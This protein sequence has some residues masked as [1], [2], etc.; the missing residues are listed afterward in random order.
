M[1]LIN[2]IIP[3]IAALL[4]LFIIVLID[5]FLQLI[6]MYSLRKANYRIALV[7]RF[8]Y[9]CSSFINI[10]NYIFRQNRII[11][12][13]F[14]GYTL[15][16]IPKRIL[17]IIIFIVRY[18]VCVGNKKE[19]LS[20]VNSLLNML[21]CGKYP[22][23]ISD[24]FSCL[25]NDKAIAIVGPAYSLEENGC[26]IDEYD[27]VIRTAYGL[28]RIPDQKIYGKKIDVSFYNNEES[29]LSGEKFFNE[30]SKKVFVIF[31][32]KLFPFQEELVLIDKAKFSSNYKIFDPG[33]AN[34]IQL[35]IQ[36]L[37]HYSPNKI[38]IFKSDLYTGSRLY[39][40]ID[41]NKNMDIISSLA[42]HDCFSQILF[43]KF[44]IK[45]TSNLIEFDDVL[46]NIVNDSL[47]VY[48]KTLEKNYK[49]N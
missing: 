16:I 39:S 30:I 9:Q 40:D 21:R 13:L 47:F 33:G 23:G 32:L 22:S 4:F 36:D 3:V 41:K 12:I 26:E 5:L 17:I 20:Y 45:V 43:F 49:T 1:E 6:Y 28:D 48:A 19:K 29:S 42:I 11:S 34:Q 35:I 44:I 24:I 25:V 27:I 2:Y 38:K 7:F 46:N 14:E 8:L 15:S 18:I 37:L 10:T 31:K